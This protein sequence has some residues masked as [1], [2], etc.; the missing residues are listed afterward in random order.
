MNVSL[1]SQQLSI[2]FSFII[3]LF[4]ALFSSV[5]LLLKQVCMCDC[6]DTSTT[7]PI[8]TY[9]QLLL[10]SLTYVLVIFYFHFYFLSYI[11][12]HLF[13]L[14]IYFSISDFFNFP[15]FILLFENRL[16]HVFFLPVYQIYCTYQFCSNFPQN[17]FHLFLKKLHCFI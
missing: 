3:H 7:M 12:I 17:L 16:F 11:F 15:R 6:L 10:G 5:C 1:L 13:F 4:I 8:C 14:K 2:L 9:F